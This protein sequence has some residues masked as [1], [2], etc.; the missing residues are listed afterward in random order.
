MRVTF[1]IN[2]LSET[3]ITGQ[4]NPI[5]PKRLRYDITVFHAS[6]FFID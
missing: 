6:G 3:L 4:Q 2:L 1:S 5:L